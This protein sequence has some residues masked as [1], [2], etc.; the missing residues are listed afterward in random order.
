MKLLLAGGALA[1]ALIGALDRVPDSP[2]H[3]G[4][5]SWLEGIPLESPR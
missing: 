2:L 5:L 1:L 4:T 3:G